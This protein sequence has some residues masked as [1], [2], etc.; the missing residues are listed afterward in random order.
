MSRAREL[1]PYSRSTTPHVPRG[2]PVT[3]VLFSH[4]PAFGRS[5]LL[6]PSSPSIVALACCISGGTVL[7]YFE[8][9]SINQIKSHMQYVYR[10][11]VQQRCN[12]ARNNVC[13]ISSPVPSWPVRWQRTPTSR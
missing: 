2:S 12:R 9:I 6:S 10:H 8:G 13:K 7:L 4:P 5:C 3:R 11:D 1:E